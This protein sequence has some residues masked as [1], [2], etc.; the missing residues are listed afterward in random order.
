MSLHANPHTSCACVFRCNLHLRF[1][2]NDRDLLRATVD[3]PFVDGRGDILLE[4]VPLMDVVGK[5]EGWHLFEDVP[6]LDFIHVPIYSHA[7]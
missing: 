6:L 7:R 1:W 5:G 4:D 2:Q 3:M